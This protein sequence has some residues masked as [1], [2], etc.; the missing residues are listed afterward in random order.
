MAEKKD[1]NAADKVTKDAEDAGVQEFDNQDAALL[2]YKATG[3]RGVYRDPSRDQEP[4]IAPELGV[5]PAPEQENLP[6]PKDSFT[7]NAVASPVVASVDEKEEANEDAVKAYNEAREAREKL[8]NEPASVSA[9][10]AQPVYMVDAPDAKDV[11]DLPA[12]S[13]SVKPSAPGKG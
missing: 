4:D 8:Y 1:P 3:Q 9:V 13:G 11:P 6:P 2:A 10:P 12:D 5:S 7:A